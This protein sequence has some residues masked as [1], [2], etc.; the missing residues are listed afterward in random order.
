MDPASAGFINKHSSS[1]GVVCNVGTLEEDANVD[2]GSVDLIMS[3]MM[4]EHVLDPRGCVEKW[5]KKLRPGGLIFIEV[6][7][8]NP[9]P[10]WWGNNADQPYWCGHITF[11]S[12]SL[13]I[14]MLESVGL[15]VLHV[16]TFDH[17]RHAEY[18]IGAGSHPYSLPS[19]PA[20]DLEPS[21]M[22]DAAMIR[23]LLRK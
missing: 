7:N 21:T 5:S 14:Q 3:S 6:P 19:D 9:V 8:E 1:T 13:L 20:E 11:F 2:D 15:S 12:P 10:Q 18:T 16:D 23:I 17:P 22:P 4:L